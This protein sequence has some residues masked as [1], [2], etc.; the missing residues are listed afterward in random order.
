MTHLQTQPALPES[1]RSVA[2]DRLSRRI[3]S[4]ALEQTADLV[5]ITDVNGKIE[6]VNHAFESCT[7]FGLNEVLGQQPS[8]LRSGKHNKSFYCNLWDTIRRGE[9]FRGVIEN[10]RKDNSIYYEEKTITPL[11]N[12]EGVI[13]NYVSTG[14]DVSENMLVQKRLRHLAYCDILTGLPNRVQVRR[15]LSQAISHSERHN[16][17]LAVLFLD[18][19]RFKNINDSLGHDLGDRL[20][21]EVARRLRRTL[22][23][24]D[25]IARNGGDEFVVLL[26]GPLN[27][28]DVVKVAN[29]LLGSFTK[30][31]TLEGH[32]HLMCVSIGISLYPDDHA[33][34]RGLLKGADIAMYQAK[35][36]GGSCYCFYSRDME[37][38]VLER[39]ELE[40]YLHRGITEN[41]LFN[42]YQPQYQISDQQLMGAEALLRWRHPNMGLISPDRFIPVAE[43]TG[44]IMSI[45]ANVLLEACQQLAA[46]R[47]VGIDLPHISV[48]LSPRQLSHP[49]LPRQV[50]ETL[51]NTGVEP[52]A[53]VLE[54][55]ESA[56]MQN[57]EQAAS[58]L[59]ELKSLGV[60][61]SVD[62]FGTG[63]SSLSYL[64]RFPLD[65]I[66]VDRSFVQDLP[67]NKEASALVEAI[68]QMAHSLNM[69][70]V[71]EGVET[72]AQLDFLN[73]VGCEGAQGY[74]MGKPMHPNDFVRH[75][76]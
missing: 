34:M 68:V 37:K 2:T 13:T 52:N 66:K 51:S 22:R 64:R 39:M 42:V 75:N 74:L 8:V 46:W 70:V 47:G 26:R 40:K 57:P 44:D 16:Q 43:D 11:I 41:E 73:Q 61:L 29:K 35:A 58:T 48:N 71:A 15:E 19:D 20:L 54:L 76:Q 27:E 67:N 36:Q 60:M 18:L 28:N 33:T 10:R 6:Y 17:S 24:D 38:R 56:L 72:D 14:R 59:T 32:K 1:E 62:D 21:R 31:F 49:G 5:M 65:C 12:D 63:H 3:L 9:V 4:Q 23:N 69:S 50:R 55:T 45:G 53:L 7:G 25:T 30:P